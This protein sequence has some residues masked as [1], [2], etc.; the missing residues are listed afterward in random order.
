MSLGRKQDKQEDVEWLER[1]KELIKIDGIVRA[2]EKHLPEA[3]LEQVLVPLDG[4]RARCS[5]PSDVKA[6]YQKE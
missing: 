3:F 2:W 1:G 4:F 5:A 6:K